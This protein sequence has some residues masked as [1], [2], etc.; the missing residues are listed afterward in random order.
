ML[1]LVVGSM[2]VPVCSNGVMKRKRNC[3]PGHIMVRDGRCVKSIN[4]DQTTS[5][6]T[7]TTTPQGEITKSRSS[8]IL[9]PTTSHDQS[10]EAAST[11]FNDETGVYE[12][13]TPQVDISQNST[14]NLRKVS[15]IT[16]LLIVGILR[17]M[18]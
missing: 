9:K 13:T 15:R 5:M 12:G 1:L 14:G 2:I 17:T 10:L 18:F 4:L 7:L 11:N 3:Q 8:V 6:D 16:M